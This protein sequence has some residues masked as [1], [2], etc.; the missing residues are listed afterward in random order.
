MDRLLYSVGRT[1]YQCQSGEK[2]IPCL[3]WKSGLLTIDVFEVFT[4][5]EL[6]MTF[7]GRRL[8]GSPKCWIL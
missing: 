1:G 3:C 2:K 4:A 5:T 6:N 8:S 7:L